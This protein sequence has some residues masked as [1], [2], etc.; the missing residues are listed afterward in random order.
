MTPTVKTPVTL[1]KPPQRQLSG[2]MGYLAATSI[3]ITGANFNLRPMSP[4]AGFDSRL[5]DHDAGANSFRCSKRKEEAF[6]FL[7]HN[8]TQRQERNHVVSVAQSGVILPLF[9]S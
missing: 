6:R 3:S 4:S 2:E 1:Q 8:N 9:M 5:I 7:G